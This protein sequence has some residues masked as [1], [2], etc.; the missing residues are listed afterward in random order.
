MPDASGWETFGKALHRASAGMKNTVG[1]GMRDLGVHVGQNFLLEE[2][3]REDGLTPGELARRLGVEVPSIT[4]AAQRMEASGLVTRV[5]D[6]GDRRLVRVTLTDQ[7]RGLRDGVTRV[8]DETSDRAL[9]GLSTAE[10]AEL[11]RLLERVGDN[12]DD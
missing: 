12:L 9:R 11:V 2:L 4:R 1:D 5:P 10:R 3:W 8:L 7:G 6:E